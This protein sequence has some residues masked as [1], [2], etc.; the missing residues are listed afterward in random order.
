MSITPLREICGEPWH[1]KHVLVVGLARSGLAC[2]RVL[3]LAGAMPRLH[4]RKPLAALPPEVSD[5]VA[6]GCEF[7]A[8]ENP[9]V[10]LDGM[11]AVI[12]SPGV[13]IDAPIIREANIRVIPVLGELEFGA[14]FARGQLYAITGTN[15]KTTTV[16]L[17]GEMLRQAGHA[18]HV[19]GNIGYPLSAAVLEAGADDPLA[20]EVSSFQLEST[21]LFHPKIAAVLNVT[22]DHL[23]RH[24][25]MERYAQLKKRVAENQTERDY[26]VLNWD[27]LL[28]RTMADMASS[29]VYW[30]SA[31]QRVP[32]GTCVMDEQVVFVDND[33][34]KVICAKEDVSLPGAH[35]LENALAA[36]CMAMLAKVPAAVIRH[37]L[38]TFAGVEHRLE[39]VLECSGVRYYNDSKGTNPDSTMR[40]IAAMQAPFVL[41]AGGENKGTPFDGLAQFA[42]NQPLMRAVVLYGETAHA[43]AA[44][45]K[46]AGIERVVVTE[47]LEAA[48]EAACGI[49]EPGFTILLSPAC[50]SFDQFD[51]YEHRGQY[52][53]QLVHNLAEREGA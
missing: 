22:P 10:I 5:L 34:Q 24:G 6:E 32:R 50:S 30:F 45:F 40:A 52:F 8:D 23:N 37:T 2:A 51:N 12:I 28:T 38:R 41:L 35:N 47:V 26:L 11:Q 44:A 9:E 42:A 16:S 7:I 15:G 4:D 1:G 20:V 29:A 14:R 13:P 19:T 18:A 48:L 49:A 27:N 3:L 43:M 33:V 36:A 31:S 25:T 46:A 17:F 21:S 39:F 53:K